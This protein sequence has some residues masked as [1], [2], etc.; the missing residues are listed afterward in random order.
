[1]KCPKCD[2]TDTKVADS[3]LTE[4]DSAIRRRRMCDHC[5][6]RFTTFER[7]DV[8]GIIVVKSNDTRE[9]YQ[10][11]KLE[12]GIWS[13]CTK[14]PVSKKQVSDILVDLEKK[15]GRQGEVQSKDIG[16]DI[17]GALRSL[18]EVAYIRFASVYRKFKDIGAFHK[19]LAEFTE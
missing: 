18:D 19:E 10:R 5:G 7:M 8:V 13:A 16:E 14:R 6:H 12:K 11:S 1:M 3:R 15:W 9:P 2:A 4:Q 17:M